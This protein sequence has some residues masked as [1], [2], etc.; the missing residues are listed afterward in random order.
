[1]SEQKKRDRRTVAVIES[2]TLVR[3]DGRAGIRLLLL[4]QETEE[5]ESI[6][7]EV[8]LLGIARFRKDLDVAEKHI[9]QSQNPPS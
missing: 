6:V 9:L 8:S 2:E 3:P 5:E 7:F 4:D 1:M